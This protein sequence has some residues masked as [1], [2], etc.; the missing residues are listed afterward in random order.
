MLKQ[1]FGAVFALALI[2]G[3]S[4]C[5]ATTGE[6]LGRNVDD[7]EITTAVKS[8]LATD[9][10]ASLTQ[11]DV[12]TV[13]G[14]VYLTGFVPDTTAKQHAEARTKEV[15]GVQQVVNNLQIEGVSAGDVP[16]TR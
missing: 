10:M 3:T 1:I 16:K 15:N 8:H 7:T 12:K 6:S 13:N 11:I 4:G 14:T 2:A 9:H 5:T